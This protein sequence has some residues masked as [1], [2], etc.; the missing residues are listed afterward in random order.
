MKKRLL[1][2]LIC[3]NITIV[4]AN[5]C[6]TH[7]TQLNTNFVENLKNLKK[8]KKILKK[9]EKSVD[10]RFEVCYSNNAFN[11]GDHKITCKSAYIK[12][13]FVITLYS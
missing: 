4:T 2:F 7:I 5:E 12:I 3:C 13:T 8:I 11:V 10:K 9:F 6:V 1:F